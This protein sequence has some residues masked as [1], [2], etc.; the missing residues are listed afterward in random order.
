MQDLFSN[1]R[2]WLLLEVMVKELQ[3]LYWDW[4]NFTSSSG[5]AGDMGVLL[6]PDLQKSDN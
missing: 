1:L 3:G 6:S 4:R 2:L 5:R